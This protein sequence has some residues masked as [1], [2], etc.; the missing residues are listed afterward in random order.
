M[1]RGFM[2]DNKQ[3]TKRRPYSVGA[4][5]KVSSSKLIFFILTVDRFLDVAE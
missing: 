5:F 4:F 2:D 3:D 1:N